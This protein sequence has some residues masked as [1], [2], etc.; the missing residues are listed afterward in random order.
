MVVYISR[1]PPLLEL[2][3]IKQPVASLWMDRRDVVVPSMDFD[4][5]K[6]TETSCSMLGMCEPLFNSRQ[7]TE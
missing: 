2:G 4:E 3:S 6:R 7:S 5:G 1:V